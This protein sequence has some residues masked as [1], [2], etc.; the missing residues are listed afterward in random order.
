M[1]KINVYDKFVMKKGKNIEIEENL[2]IN[3]HLKGDFGME[4]TAC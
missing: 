2:Y 4:F 3:I 1:G